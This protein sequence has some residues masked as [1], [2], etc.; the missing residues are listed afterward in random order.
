MVRLLTAHADER[1]D[2]DHHE[3]DPNSYIGDLLKRVGGI[4]PQAYTWSLTY[5]EKVDLI[6]FLVDRMH[7]LDSFR[8][9]LNKRL[10]DK[11]SLFK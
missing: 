3:F 5:K 6:M 2:I 9:F 8:V 4:T 10:D 1:H 7:D 11:S